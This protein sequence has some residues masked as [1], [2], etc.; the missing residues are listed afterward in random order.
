MVQ[1]LIFNIFLVITFDVFMFLNG[2]KKYKGYLNLKHYMFTLKMPIYQ[3]IL[4]IKI[5]IVVV[6]TT[7]F[8]ILI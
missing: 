8:K 2:Q 4:V 3:K 5:M 6:L 1:S 7:L